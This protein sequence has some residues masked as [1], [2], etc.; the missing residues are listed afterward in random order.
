MKVE[1]LF[2]DDDGNDIDL[3]DITYEVLKTY[4][5]LMPTAL[6]FTHVVRIRPESIDLHMRLMG[7]TKKDFE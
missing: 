5:D 3:M 6:V 7:M 1:H 2:E 4:V